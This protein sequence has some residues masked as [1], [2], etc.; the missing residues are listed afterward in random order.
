MDGLEEDRV[1]VSDLLKSVDVCIM[2]FVSDLERRPSAIVVERSP[3]QWKHK[4]LGMGQEHL[5]Y[6]VRN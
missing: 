3:N 6:W 5:L 1:P 2:P 4:M